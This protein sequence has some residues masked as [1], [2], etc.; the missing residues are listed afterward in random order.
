MVCVCVLSAYAA[1]QYRALGII[2]VA[3]SLE[4]RASCQ[5]ADAGPRGT[6]TGP[7]GGCREPTSAR[8]LCN[9][10]GPFADSPP[11]SEY[12]S[13]HTSTSVMV[14]VWQLPR[15][16]FRLCSQTKCSLSIHYHCFLSCWDSFCWCCGVLGPTETW[17]SV[18]ST[19]VWTWVCV[20]LL[21][22]LTLDY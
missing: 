19:V 5:Y 10:T 13:W 9:K 16:E 21:F 2:D 12:C 18:N 14:V 1:V 6:H 11:L 4:L 3:P 17:M 22:F 15:H 7:S 8:L 20:V